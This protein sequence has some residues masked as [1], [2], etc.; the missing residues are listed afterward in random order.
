MIK[1]INEITARLTEKKYPLGS[2]RVYHYNYQLWILSKKQLKKVALEMLENLEKDTGKK[3]PK[4]DEPIFD[5]EMNVIKGPNY[6]DKHYN[7]RWDRLLEI[8][9]GYENN[10]YNHL[11]KIKDFSGETVERREELKK[12]YRLKPIEELLDI[13]TD[14]IKLEEAI[15]KL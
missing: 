11:N 2:D 10:L 15:N 1:S 12:Q 7:G 5:D 4:E 3:I 8:V 13:L 9:E 6:N 14:K